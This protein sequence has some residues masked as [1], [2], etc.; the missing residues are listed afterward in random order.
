MTNTQQG[1]A[2]AGE[3]PLVSIIV[4]VYKVENYIQKCLDSLKAQ[5]YEQIEVLLVDDGSPDNCPA[6]C[7]AWAE[8]DSRI[9]VV[10]KENGGLSDARN[11]GM[12]AATGEYIAFVDSDDWVDENY[13]MYL[14]QGLS[15]TEADISA[16]D[17]REVRDRK[18][19]S[20]TNRN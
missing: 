12:A 4:P 5:T 11:V 10:H 7:D 14:F 6:M 1:T 16:C 8:R 15:K 17:V 18:G 19:I 3:K 13:L 9:K 2:A 20:K